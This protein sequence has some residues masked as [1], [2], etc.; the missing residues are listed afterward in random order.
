M[1][2]L[3]SCSKNDSP[4]G[5]FRA[6]DKDGDGLIKLNVFEVSLICKLNI[7]RIKT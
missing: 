4:T 1:Q 5:T 6:F 7:N 3:D 2:L